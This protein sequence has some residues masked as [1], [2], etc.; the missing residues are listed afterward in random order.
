M[1]DILRKS[2]EESI[3]KSTPKFVQRVNEMHGNHD[4]GQPAKRRYSNINVLKN[5]GN[6]VRVRD[7]SLIIMNYKDGPD[8]SLISQD[9][10]DK[11]SRK[12]R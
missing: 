2:A 1:V 6:A 4:S 11:M 7:N 10:N 8:L 9:E 3:V 5:L 12:V